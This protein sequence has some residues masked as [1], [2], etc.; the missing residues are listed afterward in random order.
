MQRAT[1]GGAWRRRIERRGVER[2]LLRLSHGG[3]GAPDPQPLSLTRRLWETKSGAE[4]QCCAVVGDGGAGRRDLPRGERFASS[5]ATWAVSSS[6][7]G[8]CSWRRG[9]PY[10]GC[11]ARRE[12]HCI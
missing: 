11:S 2:S 8:S 5:A 6:R 1:D 10:A 9:G 12:A 4:L 3:G 7:V